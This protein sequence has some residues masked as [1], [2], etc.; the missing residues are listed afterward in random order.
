MLEA[1][2]AAGDNHRHR[3]STATLNLVVQEATAW[4]APPTARGTGRKG[5]VYY[6]TQA[7]IRPPTFVL[8]VNDPKLFTED[9]MRF[10]ERQLRQDIGF[11]GTSLRL[12]LRGKPPSTRP[13]PK[14]GA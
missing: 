3:I 13:P 8:F 11:P 10:M 6:A 5:R 1:V 4:R 2:L 12:F 9:Y 14:G 7:A